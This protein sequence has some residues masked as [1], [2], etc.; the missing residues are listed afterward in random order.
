MNNIDYQKIFQEIAAELKNPDDLG[1]VA[2]YIPELANVDPAKLG[3][4]LVTVDNN[5]LR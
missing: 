2:S 1:K 5:H 4:H 3:I